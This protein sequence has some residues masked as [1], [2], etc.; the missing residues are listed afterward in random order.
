MAGAAQQMTAGQPEP[1]T[2]LQV[3][4]ANN[5]LYEL[6]EKTRERDRQRT[7]KKRVIDRLRNEGK[8]DEADL[9]EAELLTQSDVG[10][11]LGVG[12]DGQVSYGTTPHY[13]T[14]DDGN[15]YVVRYATDGTK[16][17]EP[18]EGKPF[19]VESKQPGFQREVARAKK[20]GDLG[21]Q[22]A[23]DI[24]TELAAANAS[25]TQVSYWINELESG[26]YDKDLGPIYG[27]IKKFFS[28][29]TARAEAASMEMALENLQ[30][31]NLAPVTE[32]EL[33]LVTKMG[34]N[35]YATP[36]QNIAV[37]KRVK[38]LRQFKIQS[39]RKAL[40]R[41]REEG[42]ENYILN[43]EEPEIPPELLT[44]PE[45]PD[46][47]TSDVDYIYDPETGEFKKP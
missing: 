5:E 36:E 12:S 35:P 14:D 9:I 43:P 16:I 30:I 46:T 28:P 29:D 2:A 17:R 18:V 3:L 45:N 42:Y 23:E 33:A 19:S 27:P 13:E 32:M 21:P 37:L 47:A 24:A 25:L 41:I 15:T 34:L 38:E 44:D 39:M 6:E 22:R 11:L 26:K 7:I 10:S 1:M 31:T 20:W 40:R 4:Q 8:H